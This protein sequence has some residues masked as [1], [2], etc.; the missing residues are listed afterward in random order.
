MALGK[1]DVQKQ[2]EE[3]FNNEKGHP[4]QTQRLKIMEYHEKKEKQTEQQKKIPMS[5]LMNQARLKALKVREDLI[6]DLPNEAKQRLSKLVK[7]TIRH[8]VLLDG[9]VLQSTYQLLEPQILCCW[10]Q[11]FLLVKAAVQ[12][13]NPTY[14]IATKKDVDVSIDQE[15]YLPKK[16]DG[17]VEIYNENHKIKFFNTLESPL[18]LIAQQMM[19]EA[20]GTLFGENAKKFLD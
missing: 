8:Q 4:V 10:K 14:K 6:T 11:D 17:G 18:D 13:A 15:A 3:E 12:K 5:N 1:T 19:P 9:L 7:G 2:A 16:I 20:Q